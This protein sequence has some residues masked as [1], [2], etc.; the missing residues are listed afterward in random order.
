MT[1]MSIYL[2]SHCN[3]TAIF[4]NKASHGNATINLEIIFCKKIIYKQSIKNQLNKILRVINCQVR[5][6]CTAIDIII[7]APGHSPP[8]KLN[9][10]YQLYGY[11]L[12]F[13]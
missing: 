6:L 11:M 7:A 8:S 10:P 1:K 9:Y 12:N 5:A 13:Y 3:K 4:V 2:R